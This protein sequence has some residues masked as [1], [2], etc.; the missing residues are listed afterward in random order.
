M[1]KPTIA[2]IIAC[3]LLGCTTGGAYESI[4]QNQRNQCNRLP[5]GSEKDECLQKTSEDYDGY[6]R[7]RDEA[8]K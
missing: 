6:K 3:A 5:A 2:A 1:G 7:K 8:L 4:R